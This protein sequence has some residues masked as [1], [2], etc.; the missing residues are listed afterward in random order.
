MD[1]RSAIG[2]SIITQQKYLTVGKLDTE[3]SALSYITM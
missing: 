1:H 2:L 3:N